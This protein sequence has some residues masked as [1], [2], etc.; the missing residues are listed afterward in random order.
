MAAD[1]GCDGVQGGPDKATHDLLGVVGD[2]DPDEAGLRQVLH[3]DVFGA[4]ALAL[5]DMGHGE[6]FRVC[7]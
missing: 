4:V 5:W 2:A 7:G 1:V 3:P 6:A